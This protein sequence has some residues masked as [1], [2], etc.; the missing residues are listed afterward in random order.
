MPEKPIWQPYDDFQVGRFIKCTGVWEVAKDQV[1]RNKAGNSFVAASL[2]LLSAHTLSRNY[3]ETHT[4]RSIGSN[5]SDTYFS[6]EVEKISQIPT[7]ML[8]QRAP[9]QTGLLYSISGN[10][11]W[12]NT[13]KFVFCSIKKQSRHN[14]AI[15]IQTSQCNYNRITGHL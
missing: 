5:I 3:S 13:R 8:T 14:C 6:N 4:N 11:A 2:K 10:F 12:L 9:E 1:I 7:N 15:K